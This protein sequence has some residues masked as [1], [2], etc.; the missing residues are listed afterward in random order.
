VR[1]LLLDRERVP[2]THSSGRN[3]AIARQ[4][5]DDPAM[6]RLAKEGVAFLASPHE[7][8]AG[9]WSGA[10]P[11]GRWSA[12]VP[13]LE[14]CGLLL[15]Q[16]ERGG[17][18]VGGIAGTCRPKGIDLERLDRA[19]IGR[20]WP[21][22]AGGRFGAGLLSTGDGVVDVHALLTGLL[23]AARA[24]GAEVDLGRPAT[25]FLREADRVTGV[26]AEGEAVSAGSVVIAAGAWSRELAEAA[27]APP[28]PIRVTR[29]HLFF[30]EPVEGRPGPA[31][32][33]LELEGEL[34]FRREATGLL[35]SP[36]DIEPDIPGLPST[37][38]EAEEYLLRKLYAA[39]PALEGLRMKRGWA[40]LRVLAP[41]DRHL[42]G[43][44]PAVEGLHWAVALGG[45]GVTT[46]WPSGRL[47]AAGVTGGRIDPAFAPGRFHR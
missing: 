2:G 41:D 19:E 13:L 30:S 10:S 46:A 39:F 42:L 6:A 12:E 40:G 22:L 44:D 27:G 4:A 18:P 23:E 15:L 36:C 5:V 16:Q 26:E 1:V 11:P 47:A 21:M 17:G 20:R 45:H 25:G 3:A 31:V 35:L 9:A 33:H 7:A 24:M 32:W 34:Y 28:P 14:R 8:A 43:P 38:L 37:T 29:R